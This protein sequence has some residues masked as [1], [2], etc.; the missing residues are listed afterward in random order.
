MKDQ[1]H[2]AEIE[3]ELRELRG[4]ADTLLYWIAQGNFSDLPVPA[5]EYMQKSIARI[6]NDLRERSVS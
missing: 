2:I 6:R 4:H 3:R 1:N 5:I